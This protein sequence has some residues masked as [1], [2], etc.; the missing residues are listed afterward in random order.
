VCKSGVGVSYLDLSPDGTASMTGTRHPSYRVQFSQRYALFK[1]A[2]TVQ[3]T[4]FEIEGC[5]ANC[6]GYFSRVAGDLRRWDLSRGC[7]LKEP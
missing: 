7:F 1:D 3:H 2:F 4:S 5:T 6:T